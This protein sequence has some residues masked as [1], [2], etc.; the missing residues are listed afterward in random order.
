MTNEEHEY[1]EFLK[2]TYNELTDAFINN[3]NIKKIILLFDFSLENSFLYL[4]KKNYS[5]IFE[6][7]NVN[8]NDINDMLKDIESGKD[9]SIKNIIKYLYDFYEKNASKLKNALALK[10][11]ILILDGNFY[12]LFPTVF[13][14]LIEIK[15]E[16]SF[17]KKENNEIIAKNNKDDR[18][19]IFCFNDSKNESIEDI[20]KNCFLKK[21]NNE[22]FINI[23]PSMDFNLIYSLNNDKKIPL[24]FL[25][26]LYFGTYT[27]NENLLSLIEE[28]VFFKNLAT[29]YDSL[30]NI[31]TK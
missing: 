22:F 7:I 11:E 3:K 15:K 16:F 13:L 23:I 5:N 28:K 25:N 17:I 31:L 26:T 1:A 8:I 24:N 27:N 21:F 4:K 30:F 12:S 6:C 14:S 18:K 29:D 20:I 9:N 10:K 2:K 19:I